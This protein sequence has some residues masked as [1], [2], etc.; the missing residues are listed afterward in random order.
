LTV[1]SRN[2]LGRKYALLLGN[3]EVG[4]I[5][6]KGLRGRTMRLEF[7]DEVPVAL[8]VLLVYL[9]VCQVKREAAASSGG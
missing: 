4:W 6:R 5:E 8:Q 2:W 9:V 7:P 3:Q 1:E